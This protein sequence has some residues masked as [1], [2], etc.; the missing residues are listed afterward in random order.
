MPIYTIYG[1]IKHHTKK[2]TRI[3]NTPLHTVYDNIVDWADLKAVLLAAMRKAHYDH[4]QNQVEITIAKHLAGRYITGTTSYR[5]SKIR[6]RRQ[7]ELA[8]KVEY[9]KDKDEIRIQKISF[10]PTFYNFKPEYD[11]ERGKKWELPKTVPAG[12]EASLHNPNLLFIDLLDLKTPTYAT[13]PKNVYG[14]I[15][16]KRKQQGIYAGHSQG[17]YAGARM[18]TVEKDK[19]EKENEI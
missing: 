14:S 19:Q 3:R 8:A 15:Q 10:G 17:S 6:Y 2:R 11:L 13:Q 16:E 9:L 12:F 5:E 1:K 18:A 4:Q 7:P